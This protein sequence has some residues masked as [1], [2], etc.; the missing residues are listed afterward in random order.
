[1]AAAETFATEA[2]M[3]ERS[4]GAIP[5][6]RP[7]LLTELKAATNLIRN[8]C[9]WHIAGEVTDHAIFDGVAGRR[10]FLPTIHVTA[11]VSVTLDGVTLDLDTDDLQWSQSGEVWRPSWSGNFRS[12]DVEF[13]HGFEN[14]PDDLI[15]LTCQ[16]A[17][18]ALMSPTGAVRE[19]TLSSSVT[20]SQPG[21]N[22]AG[23]LVLLDHEKDALAEYRVGSIP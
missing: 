1:M 7:F 18:R 20:W 12:I 21:F 5:A 6:D 9:G 8:H 13:T 17:A 19:Q 14:I 15:D 16:I 4:K 3:A 22:V 11:L 10:I 2:Q 23:G